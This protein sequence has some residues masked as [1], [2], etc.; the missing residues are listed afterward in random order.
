MTE[1]QVRDAAK[2]SWH[3]DLEPIVLAAHRVM[4]CYEDTRGDQ[5]DMHGAM[6]D[7]NKELQMLVFGKTE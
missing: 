7:L 2:S 6:A 3:E 1:D 4:R 5:G